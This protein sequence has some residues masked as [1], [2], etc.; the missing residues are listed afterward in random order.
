MGGQVW[1]VR[2]SCHTHR[3]FVPCQSAGADALPA[4]GANVAS[5]PPPPPAPVP[6]KR[7]SGRAHLDIEP[8]VQLALLGRRR[9]LHR[10]GRLDGEPVQHRRPRAPAGHLLCSQQLLNQPPQVRAR[11]RREREP[12]ARR[13]RVHARERARERRGVGERAAGRRGRGGVGQHAGV[14][15]RPGATRARRGCRRHRCCRVLWGLPI[16]E[17]QGRRHLPGQRAV[18]AAAA[19]QGRLW[20]PALQSAGAREGCVA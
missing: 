5:P 14:A 16:C 12:R 2:H 10:P 1:G 19:R 4:A 13:K 17:L 8:R 20:G 9:R 11:R 18:A 15:P 3:W 6:A 7:G